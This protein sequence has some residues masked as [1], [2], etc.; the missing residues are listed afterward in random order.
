MIFFLVVF[1]MFANVSCVIVCE[2][3]EKTKAKANPADEEKI[4]FLFL[5]NFAMSFFHAIQ[6]V[7]F[8]YCESTQSPRMLF[9]R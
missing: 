8:C 2:E 1:A 3:N 7:K 4:F 6:K 5:Y 9:E